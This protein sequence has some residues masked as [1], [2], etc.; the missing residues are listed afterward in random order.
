MPLPEKP[1]AIGATTEIFSWE[2]GQI[3]K[4]FRDWFSADAVQTEARTARLI[5]AS[6]A[7]VPAVG[8]IVEISGRIGLLYKRI[9]GHSMLVALTAQP[10][11]ILVFAR[12]L[13]A[14]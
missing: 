2:N 3:L 4:L 1:I 5:H 10:W 14:L 11:R 13:A 9:D 12:Q 6:G 7:P 8:E